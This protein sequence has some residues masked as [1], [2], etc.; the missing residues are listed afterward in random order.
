M[1]TSLF[2]LDSHGAHLSGCIMPLEGMP[3]LHNPV[4]I[5]PGQLA[6]DDP[7]VRERL[8]SWQCLPGV[9][10]HGAP[11]RSQTFAQGRSSTT[12]LSGIPHK[13][14]L[15]NFLI[16]IN[17]GINPVHE[18]SFSVLEDLDLP[19]AVLLGSAIDA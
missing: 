5:P 15:C 16:T 1:G 3:V 2:L 17:H 12:I 6:R 10:D 4:M 13:L 14:F 7:V 8:P 11:A 9:L 18:A 19:M